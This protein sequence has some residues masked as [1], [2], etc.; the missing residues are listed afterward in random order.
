M[1][2]ALPVRPAMREYVR[3]GVRPLAS[4]APRA[5]RSRAVRVITWNMGLADR[6]RRFVKTHEQA[7][8]YVL[9][10]EPDLAFL[11]EAFPPEW[12]AEEGTIVRGP[13]EKWG[14]LIFS[15]RP[16]IEPF[17]LPE[18][19][20]LRALPGYYAAYGLVQLPHGTEVIGASI[21]ARPARAEGQVLGGQDPAKLRRSAEGP[22]FNDVVFAG[23]VPLV[24][25]RP[26]IVAGDWNTARRQGTKRGSEIGTKFFDRVRE[27]GWSDCVWD[28]RQDEFRTWFGPGKL[29]QDDYVFCDTTFGHSVKDVSVATDAATE[30]HLSDHAPLIIDFSD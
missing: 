14:S 11:Q 9:E 12:A 4:K 30:L 28:T 16:H 8:R 2:P 27:A 24:E 18:T 6:T 15:R 26:F 10:L 7:W 23:L 13:F 21:H 17:T 25:R 19:S 22:K 3:P 5:S 29:Q 20:P 1:A